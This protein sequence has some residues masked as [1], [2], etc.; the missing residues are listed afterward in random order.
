MRRG[1]LVLDVLLVAVA[2]WLAVQLQQA[3]R[4]PG[5]PPA[6]APVAPGPA[7]PPAPAPPTPEA[8]RA[9]L[10]AYGV[11][12]E[13]NLFSPNRTELPPE[14]P[15]PATAAAPPA[16]PAPKPRLYGIILLPDG[17]SRAYLEDVQRRRVFGY[18]VGDAVVDSRLEQI[19][20]DRV[21]LRRGAEVY[22]V[23]LRDPSKPRAAGPAGAPGAGGAS[24]VPTPSPGRPAPGVQSP[25]AGATPRAG[26]RTTPGVTGSMPPT[27]AIGP[28][29]RPR[30]PLPAPEPRQDGP[31]TTSPD[32]DE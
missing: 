8:S 10:T 26:V 31:Q 21:V 6:S 24:A 25:E 32:E 14:P 28:R 7:E 15:R 17:K 1:L 5:G 12:A 29:L 4:A 27:S 11:V 19:K 16:P 2:A 20:P 18:S 13:R 30:P 23:L 22:E 3:W 9:P